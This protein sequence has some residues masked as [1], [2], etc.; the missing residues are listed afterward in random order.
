MLPGLGRPANSLVAIAG[1]H[2][3]A[4]SMGREPAAGVRKT[5]SVFRTPT[6]GILTRM[7]PTSDAPCLGLLIDLEWLDLPR[8]SGPIEKVRDSVESSS[9]AESDDVTGPGPTDA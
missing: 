3:H 9:G 2:Y 8:R 4:H 1:R 7:N 6:L 5:R